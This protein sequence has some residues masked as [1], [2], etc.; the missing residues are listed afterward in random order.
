M[1][2]SARNVGGVELD[3]CVESSDEEYEGVVDSRVDVDRPRVVVSVTASADGRVTLSRST[4]LLEPE[5]HA[6]WQSLTPAGAQELLA[7]RRRWI[8]S[9]HGF[10]VVLEAAGTFITEDSRPA[11]LPAAE[12]D[13]AVLMQSY[14]PDA[15]NRRWFVVDG[16]GRIRWRTHKGDDDAHLLVLV[17]S[18]TP[19]AYLAYL[20]REEI[21]YLMAGGSRIDLLRALVALKTHLGA[22]CVL[23]EAGGGLNSAL[24]RAGLV[25]ELHLV[26]LPALIGGRDTPT[27]FDGPLLRS[28]NEVRALRLLHLRNSDDGAVWLHYAVVT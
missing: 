11:A 17:C 13:R 24:L 10:R 20:R 5:V 28:S 19:A 25:D 3:R 26:L 1:F 23:S 4:T 6:I 27:T 7:E 12:I 18:S 16:R 22:S 2:A 14:L 21:P 8:E 9:R 15:R